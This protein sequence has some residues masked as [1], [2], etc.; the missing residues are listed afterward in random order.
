[1]SEDLTC[2]NAID[3]SLRCEF[4]RTHG[5]GIHTSE[6]RGVLRGRKYKIAYDLYLCKFCGRVDDDN[7]RSSCPW[8]VEAV[9]RQEEINSQ[10]LQEERRKKLLPKPKTRKLALDKDL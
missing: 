6:T 4:I 3:A 5:E 9:R 2:M 7:N 8:K 1:M 10:F